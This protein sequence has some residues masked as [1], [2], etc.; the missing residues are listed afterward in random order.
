MADKKMGARRGS[1]LGEIL[2]KDEKDLRVPRNLLKAVQEGNCIAFVGAGFSA[3]AGL[4]GWAALL[5]GMNEKGKSSGKLS[6]VISKEITETIGEGTSG[7]FDRAAQML[8]DRM[9]PKM[10]ADVA[11]EML[12]PP[13]TLSDC[14]K[15]RMELLYGIP[16][17]A[18]LTTNF[19][20]FLPGVPAAHKSCKNVMRDILRSSPL[21][22]AEQVVRELLLSLNSKSM[23]DEEEEMGEALIATTGQSQS[24]FDDLMQEDENQEEEEDEKDISDLEKM[25]MKKQGE[26]AALQAQEYLKKVMCVPTIQLHGTVVPKAN[27]GDPPDGVLAPLDQKTQEFFEKNNYRANPGL[28][29]TSLG[30]RRLLHGNESYTKF[31]QS[32]MATKTVLYIGFSFADEYIKELRSSTMMM[33][34]EDADEE[35]GSDDSGPNISDSDNSFGGGDEDDEA[36]EDDE[37]DEGDRD[38]E[39]EDASPVASRPKAAARKSSRKSMKKKGSKHSKKESK[40]TGD[41]L[42]GEYVDYDQDAVYIRRCEE[43]AA[44]LEL[45][46]VYE[47]PIVLKLADGQDGKD[48]WWV[49]EDGLRVKK[50]D[51]RK[52]TMVK[53]DE[54]DGTEQLMILLPK[55]YQ[56][57]VSYGIS[58]NWKP[59]QVEHYEKHEGVRMLNYVPKDGPGFE[60]LDKWL[61]ALVKETNPLY[62]WCRSLAEKKILVIAKGKRQGILRMMHSYCSSFFKGDFATMGTFVFIA[63]PDGD[64]ACNSEA[65]AGILGEAFT[66]HGN[67]STI[68]VSWKANGH[69]LATELLQAMGELRQDGKMTPVVVME[70]ADKKFHKKHKK[71]ALA[72]GA[73]GYVNSM[74]SMFDEISRVVELPQV[75]NAMEESLGEGGGCSVM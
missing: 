26:E 54:D 37:D 6:A 30:Y 24:S 15:T 36:P 73:A 40:P 68:V 59:G 74:L 50:A 55:G 51:G 43:D 62:R 3:A 5:H 1:L 56:E 45:E 27:N 39:D 69:N 18:I 20:Y 53:V 14:M 72:L 49:G 71:Q 41:D 2:G 65:L 31:L 33:L 16:F 35:G 75:P 25:K 67:F 22:L 13:E 29:F 64:D 48:G 70:T 42:I 66:E 58:I 19:D 52:V 28:A 44:C 47:M 23:K 21:S 38:E 12:K 57:P 11:G 17:A 10:M 8:E 46:T 32:I 9:G 61:A 7:A 34:N 4:P 63:P 60:G